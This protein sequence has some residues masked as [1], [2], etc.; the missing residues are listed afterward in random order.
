VNQGLIQSLPGRELIELRGNGVTVRGTL[1]NGSR[2]STEG[3]IGVVFLNSLS[4]PRTATGDSAVYWAECFAR[5]GYPSFRLDLPGL[6]DSGG[7]IPAELLNYINGGEYASIATAKMKELVQSFRLSGLVIAGHCA[8][9]VT[10]TY[11]AAGCVKDCK[12]LLLLDPYFHL[13]QAVRPVVRR[14]LSEWAMQN[15]LGGLLSNVYR[16]AKRVRLALRGNAL[17]PNA[18]KKLLLCWKK[19]ASS[20][21]PILFFKAPVRNATGTKPREGEFDY[22][23]YVLGVAGTNSNVQVKLV[24]ETDHSFANLTGRT[25]VASETQRWLAQHVPLAK[26]DETIVS[27]P[28]VTTAVDDDYNYS[29]HDCLQS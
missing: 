7:A 4:L 29:H 18:N 28:V 25:A 20:G 17:P 10:A 1:H 6:G 2:L 26:Q 5:A 9:T 27:S 21:L 24:E 12:G 11:A 8:G 19:V 23:S 13:P 22:L 3:C 14:G 15:R 16:R